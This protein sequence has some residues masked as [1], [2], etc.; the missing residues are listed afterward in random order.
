M[1]KL[2]LG[3][4][5]V[6]II[7]C[8][9]LY[10]SKSFSGGYEDK[11]IYYNEY[12]VTFLINGYTTWEEM[13]DYGILRVSELA[14]ENGYN[15]FMLCSEID[16]TPFPKE[17][18]QKLKSKKMGHAWM[19]VVG[20]MFKNEPRYGKDYYYDAKE[21]YN[22]IRAKYH[23]KEKTNKSKKNKSVDNMHI[24]ISKKITYY[25]DMLNL[26]PDIKKS[27]IIFFDEKENL[28]DRGFLIGQYHDSENPYSDIGKFKKAIEKTEINPKINA[29]KIIEFA[30]PIINPEIISFATF[31]MSD[32]FF[33]QLFSMPKY[34]LGLKFE[35]D[36]LKNKEYI[37][38]GFYNK[39]RSELLR[40]SD[41]IIK[42]NDI[43]VL[44]SQQIISNWFS[45][46]EN[47]IIKLEV[48]REG[49]QLHILLPVMEN[50]LSS[51]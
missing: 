13:I 21:Y 51:K 4:I 9:T 29:I 3:L 40:L 12:L 24:D 18:F 30:N 35:P 41:K 14:V 46:E 15:Y 8:A 37:I 33:A 43:D 28:L 20:K 17:Y 23:I 16:E 27:E 44:D 32:Q 49:K 34:F 48:I 2:I 50:I 47:T 7:N 10:Q 11:K 38:R 1:Q 26:I 36:R 42:I 22:N 19:K 25:S 45:W 39:S 31:K 6:F 5:S